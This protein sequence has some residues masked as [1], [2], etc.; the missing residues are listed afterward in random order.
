M[1]AGALSLSSPELKIHL[2]SA[3]STEPIDVEQKQAFETNSLV[4]EFML[5]AN[6]SVAAKIQETFPATAVL[7]R[8]SP[9]PKTNFEA[10]QDILMKRKGM[11][12]DV[13]SSGA[14]AKSLDNCVVSPNAS[15]LATKLTLRTRSCPSSI[16]SSESWLRGVCLPPGISAPVVFQRS[17]SAIMVS[18][19]PST[20]IS[21]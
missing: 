15:A 6:I 19:R 1:R 11:E 20:L 14:L 4:E 16:R 3:E 13:S 2:A 9:P 17:R 12:L 5:L 7:R 21:R 18:L 8:H 10:L